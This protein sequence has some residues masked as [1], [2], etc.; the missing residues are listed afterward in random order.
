VTALAQKK[1]TERTYL[2]TLDKLDQGWSTRSF[3][4]LISDRQLYVADNV[5][6]QRDGL[7]SKRPGNIHYGNSG[8]G[9]T[10][11]GHAVIS[12]TRFYVGGVTP[13]LVV[14]S[15]GS[16]Y[17]GNDGTGAFTSVGTGLSTTQSANYAQVYDPDMTTGAAVALVIVDGSRIPQLWDGTHFTAVRSGTP[18]LPNNSMTATALRPKYVVNWKYHLVYSGDA[19][20]P[21]GV[22]IG[23]ALFPEMFTGTSLTSSSGAS[24]LPYYPMGRG[25]NCGI[26]T[27]LACV[28]KSIIVFFTNG[29]AVGVNTGTYGAYEFDWDILS[30]QVGCPSP[31]SICAFGGYIVFFGGDRFYATDGQSVVPLPDE[32][33]SVYSQGGANGTFPSDIKNFATVCGARRGLRYLASY[34]N[35]GSGPQTAIACFDISANNGWSY[36]SP[37]GGAWS[38]FPTG[39]PLAFGIEGRGPGDQ[40]FPFFWGSSQGDVVAQWDTGV[41]GDFGSPIAMEVRTKAFFLEVPTAVK[42]VKHIHVIAAFPE[43]FGA[44]TY[45]DIIQPY[46]FFDYSQVLGTPIIVSVTTGG[47]SYNSSVQMN[48]TQ[49]YGNVTDLYTAV[50]KS[51]ISQD[52]IGHLVQPGLTESSINPCNVIAFVVELE[53]REPVK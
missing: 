17:K 48:A 47:I 28:G 31:N 25:G 1:G 49:Q 38:R 41:Y 13:Q 3:P 43:P 24:F 33:P 34:D 44:G 6:F 46:C 11:S 4:H 51:W 15:N 45:T 7:I 14:Q 53:I 22:Y 29:I 30:Q 10:G 9:A 20:D 42:R 8:S 12:G 39:M 35:V 23:D 18:F 21:T 50:S 52:A 26:V 37:T 2:L 16:L 36:G 40:A 5:L 32:V 19:A 27:G